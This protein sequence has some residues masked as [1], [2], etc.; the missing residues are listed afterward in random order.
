MC[1]FAAYSK[2]LTDVNFVHVN[3]VLDAEYCFFNSIKNADP[4]GG[5]AFCDISSCSSLVAEIAYMDAI[6]LSE[7]L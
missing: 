3:G 1:I 7:T 5:A 4:D 2:I 6:G